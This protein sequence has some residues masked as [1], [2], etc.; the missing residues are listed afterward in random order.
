M[1]VHIIITVAF[2]HT[3][4]AKHPTRV[5][6]WAG[7]SWQERTGVCIFEGKINAPLFVAILDATLSQQ[8]IHAIT[9]SCRIMILNIR[10]DG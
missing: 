3:Y 5:H 2:D 8:C 7:I 1:C 9:G 6:V 4:R 10:L